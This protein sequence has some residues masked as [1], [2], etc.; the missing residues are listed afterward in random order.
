MGQ[1][2][3]ACS[4]LAFNDRPLAE[5]LKEISGLGFQY[6]DL[7]VFPGTFGHLDPEAV[8]ADLQ[9]SSDAVEAACRSTGV[10]IA[11]LNASIGDAEGTAAHRLVMGL[12]LFAHRVDATVVT[13][14]A[15]NKSP[16]E[17]ALTLAPWIEIG[18]RYG[19]K[20]APE[21]HLNNVTERPDGCRA[22]ARHLPA[23]RFTLDPSHILIQQESL[24]DWADV[25][26][27]TAHVHVRDAGANGWAD[28]QVPWGTGKVDL[29][30]LLDRLD[31]IDYFGTISIEYIHPASMQQQPW[32]HVASIKAAKDAI[33]KLVA[34]PS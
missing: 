5:A 7:A 28:V 30:D 8:A 13:I 11:A 20:L 25:I 10:Q 23:V 26:Q 27:R 9:K 12:L 34:P 3:L 15:G 1:V 18:E 14:P 2:R 19:V 29:A 17:T 32:D 21:I 24:A 4:T 22:V 16:E 33:L 31:K 6:A